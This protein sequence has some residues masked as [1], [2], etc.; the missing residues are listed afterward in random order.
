[1]CELELLTEDKTDF[2]TRSA[3][4]DGFEQ[5]HALEQQNTMQW[6]GT[7]RLR[8]NIPWQI[9]ITFFSMLKYESVM[10]SR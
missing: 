5:M 9:Q 1:V 2:A 10:K 8:L 7:T 4:A 6:A 3:L